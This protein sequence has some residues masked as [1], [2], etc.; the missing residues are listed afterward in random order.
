MSLEISNRVSL[1]VKKDIKVLSDA[2]DST[3]YSSDF[4]SAHIQ[5]KQKFKKKIKKKKIRIT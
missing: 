3:H 2:Y 5:E 1:R 4:H